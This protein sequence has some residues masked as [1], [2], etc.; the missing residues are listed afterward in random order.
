MFS[1]V[2]SQSPRVSELLRS[3]VGGG[4][5]PDLSSA[6]KCE[7]LAT[8]SH[9][10]KHWMWLGQCPGT[11]SVVT[12]KFHAPVGGKIT[13]GKSIHASLR[14]HFGE[15]TTKRGSK[16]RKLSLP[17]PFSPKKRRLLS[18]SKAELKLCM[19]PL[20]WRRGVWEELIPSACLKPEAS[21]VGSIPGLLR[22][23]PLLKAL[24]SA[25]FCVSK[26]PRQLRFIPVAFGLRR[27]QGT[28]TQ[29]PGSAKPIL[30][31]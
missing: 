5:H 30:L 25:I 19:G 18:A 28:P 4:T 31:H 20:G 29:P 12:T 13:L 27:V 22:P 1:Q 24:V 15:K 8:I 7:F 10:S 9:G 14:E 16:R 11:L 6:L 23:P 17:I 3:Y 2:H 26:Q 21:W